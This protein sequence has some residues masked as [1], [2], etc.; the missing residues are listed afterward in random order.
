MKMKILL[1]FSY[2]I[3][4]FLIRNKQLLTFLFLDIEFNLWKQRLRKNSSSFTPDRTTEY[5]EMQKILA[6]IG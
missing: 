1:Y 6:D 4:H 2:K 5:N 3:R